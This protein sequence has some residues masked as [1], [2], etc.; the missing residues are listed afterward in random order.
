MKNCGGG[1]RDRNVP[2]VLHRVDRWVAGQGDGG[3]GEEGGKEVKVLQAI[4]LKTL[5][6]ADAR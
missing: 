2:N 4:G 6:F 1:I 3:C 5:T